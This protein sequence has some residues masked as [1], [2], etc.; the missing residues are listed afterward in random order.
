MTG[1][2]ELLQLLSLYNEHFPNESGRLSRYTTFLHDTDGDMLIARSNFNGHITT[3]AFIID[4]A[5]SR[6]LLLQH[7]SLG[8]WLQPGG[9]AEEQ[10]A[11]LL[12]SALR[13]A[14]EETGI[15]P[16]QLTYYPIHP[17]ALV[18]FDIDAHYIPAN[19]K[20]QEDGHYH[21]DH[22]YLFIYTGEHDNQY[23]PAEST[24]M[25]WVS[26][27]DLAGDATFGAMVQKISS[28]VQ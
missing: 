2:K 3:S 27:T 21:Y 1:K 14:V 20:K 10:D 6:M 9:H 5:A 28:Q 11:S 15:R 26:F 8:R 25:R 7:K 13:E 16:D 18:P 23:D 12:T 4:G 17:V 19:P 24:G 22:R